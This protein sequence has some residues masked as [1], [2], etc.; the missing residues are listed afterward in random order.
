MEGFILR[1]EY[2]GHISMIRPYLNI[3][4]IYNDAFN[5]IRSG[6]MLQEVS[7]AR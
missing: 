3:F 2:I 5:F 4:V 7:Y 6:D 1:S